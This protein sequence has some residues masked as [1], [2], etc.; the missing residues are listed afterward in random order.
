LGASANGELIGMAHYLY[1]ASTWAASVC[2]LQDLF[3]AEK[4]RGQ[5]VARQLIEAVAAEVK[6]SG[7]ARF[8][9]LTQDHNTAARALY[10]KV[11]EHRGFIRYD[12]DLSRAARAV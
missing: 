11:G 7:C 12:Y 9:W 4:A 1:H 10:D 8:Y 3:V 5:G 6:S 2:Y